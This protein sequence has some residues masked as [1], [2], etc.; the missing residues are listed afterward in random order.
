MAVILLVLPHVVGAPQPTE[1]EMLVPETLAHSFVVA[2]TVTS[3]LFWV[4]LGVLSAVFFER[5]GRS[6]HELSPAA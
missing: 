2:V 4:A 3:F 6:D 5:F 1:G